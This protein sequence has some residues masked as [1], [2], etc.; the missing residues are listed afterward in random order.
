[1]R[2]IVQPRDPAAEKNVF[3][4]PFYLFFSPPPESKQE[5]VQQ[6]GNYGRKPFISCAHQNEK[7]ARQRR[8]SNADLRGGIQ[9]S[10][11]AYGCYE[12]Q[13]LLRK[14]PFLFSPTATLGLFFCKTI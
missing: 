6:T 1:M 12:V 5:A 2:H 11:H 10:R 3:F 7:S 4:F 8:K 13:W 14:L 9:L